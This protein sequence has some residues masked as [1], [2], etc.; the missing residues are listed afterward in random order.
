MF[1]D[2]WVIRQFETVMIDVCNEFLNLTVLENVDRVLILQKGHL[3][4]GKTTYC[5]FSITG[6][7]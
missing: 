1:H 2:L 7:R 4:E 5:L 3:E 6:G